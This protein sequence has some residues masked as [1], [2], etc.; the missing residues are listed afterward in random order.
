MP[1]VFC[2][3]IC[4]NPGSAINKN[5]LLFA[6]FGLLIKP[7]VLLTFEFNNVLQ[8]STELYC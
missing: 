7:N 4:R 6:R 1:N 8:M 3:V 5:A 2:T